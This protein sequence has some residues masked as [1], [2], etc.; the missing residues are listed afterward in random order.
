MLDQ[1]GLYLFFYAG[2]TIMCRLRYFQDQKPHS[3]F[4]IFSPFSL[5]LFLFLFLFPPFSL[6]LSL[7]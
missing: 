6:S 4:F 5:S 2:L 1:V 7:S 3:F